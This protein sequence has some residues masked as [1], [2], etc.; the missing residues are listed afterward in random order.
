MNGLHE[1][2]SRPIFLT[3]APWPGSSP[4]AL[5]LRRAGSSHQNDLS[6]KVIKVRVMK[7]VWSKDKRVMANDSEPLP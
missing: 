7:P 4:S 1:A 2:M 6:G 5:K 3:Y